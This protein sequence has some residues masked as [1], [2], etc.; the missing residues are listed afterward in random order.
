MEGS[1]SMTDR[2]VDLR[3]SVTVFVTTVGFPTFDACLQRLR[4]QDCNFD[5]EVIDH[6][7]PMSAAFQR[8]LERCATPFYVQVDEDM[9]LYPHAVRTLYERISSM[10]ERVVQYVAALFDVHLERVIYGLKIF[11]HEVIRQYPYRNVRGCE[12]DQIRRFRADGYADV[13]VPIA[14]A[15]R[16]SE[17][18][19][20][21]HGTYWTPETIYLR[22]LTL[23]LTRRSGNRTHEWLKEAAPML[24]RRFL[25]SRSELDFY[26]LMGVLAAGLP[27]T[28]PLG[29]EKDYTRYG[30]LPGL[31]SLRALV[32]EVRAAAVQGERL[33]P[34][35]GDADLLA[36]TGGE[37]RPRLESG[38]EARRG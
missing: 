3:G 6:V 32:N 28:M 12:W 9:L 4:E 5:L 7:A 20:G 18:T 11:R 24:L 37:A 27:D 29:E 25:E 23:G 31:Q 1:R 36:K 26:A 10:E 8:M 22:F 30:R 2:N 21:L 14:G 34:G 13:R 16:H 35:E 38:L 15:S 19:L 33:R 17:H